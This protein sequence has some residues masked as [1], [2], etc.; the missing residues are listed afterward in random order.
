MVR[1]SELTAAPQNPRPDDCITLREG[2]EPVPEEQEAE[3]EPGAPDGRPR[4]RK[5]GAARGEPEE[6]PRGKRQKDFD[7]LEANGWS[8]EEV[9]KKERGAAEEPWTQS[10]QKLLEAA[11]QQY[12]KGCS[13]RWDRIA[14]C[15]PSKSKVGAGRPASPG[16]ESE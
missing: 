14:K 15:V 9:P 6:R 4:R 8:D 2:G 5:P 7:V 10:Q 1:L 16:P 3:P 13:D 12:P 11:L